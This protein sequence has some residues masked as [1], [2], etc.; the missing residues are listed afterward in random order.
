MA[1]LRS[2]RQPED[3]RLIAVTKYVGVATIQ[4]LLAAGCEDLGEARPQDLWAKPPR[5]PRRGIAGT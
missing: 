2:G 5:S 1:A 4:A 3:V